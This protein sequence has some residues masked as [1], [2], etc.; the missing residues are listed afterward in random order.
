MSAGNARLGRV[1]GRRGKLHDYKLHGGQG[2]LLVGQPHSRKDR[3]A[4]SIW[5]LAAG[6]LLIAMSAVG[7]A[8]GA[9]TIARHQAQA[10]ADLGALAGA[11]R[12]AE[13]SVS[14]CSRA[15]GIVAANG[16]RLVSCVLD[17][18]ELIVAVDVAVRP[19]RGIART[20]HAAARAGPVR[21]P[22]DGFDHVV[23]A[24][25]AQRMRSCAVGG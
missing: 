6:L 9:A 2:K 12:A 21:A 19:I 18:F 17:G 16:G 7:A 13:G 8:M 15:A 3:G 22:P 5:L 24:E 23:V 20:A 11:A 1:R 4:A 14:A 10:A 25:R